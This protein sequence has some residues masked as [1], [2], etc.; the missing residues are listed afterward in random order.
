MEKRKRRKF[1][2]E[3]KLKIVKEGLQNNVS[4]SEI[5]RHYE[6]YPVDYY[7]WK[8]TI[9]EAALSEMKKPKSKEKKLTRREEKLLE[10]NERLKRVILQLTQEHMELKKKVYGSE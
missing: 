4:V 7:R 6:I 8:R 1:S 5:C 2:P 9:E 3:L 10:E